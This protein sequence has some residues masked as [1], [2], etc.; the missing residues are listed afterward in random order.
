MLSSFLN[1]IPTDMGR[2]SGLALYS[3]PSSRW[4]E[5]IMPSMILR[6]MKESVFMFK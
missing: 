4:P 3:L 2:H 5:S 6:F 1:Y